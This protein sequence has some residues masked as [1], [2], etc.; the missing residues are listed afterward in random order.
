M[1]KRAIIQNTG[2][3]E[4]SEPKWDVTPCPECTRLTEEVELLRDRHGSMHAMLNGMSVANAALRADL[5][6]L[7]EAGEAVMQWVD[8]PVEGFADRTDTATPFTRFR[9]VL[10]ETKL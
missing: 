3:H 8:G 9:T 2:E 7:H 10:D 5:A 4:M 6:R 1:R